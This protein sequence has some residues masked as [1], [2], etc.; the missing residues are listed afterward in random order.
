MVF[1]RVSQRHAVRWP[2][3]FEPHLLNS[4]T[5]ICKTFE[6]SDR[7]VKRWADEGAPIVVEGKDAKRRY[8]AELMDLHYWRVRRSATR[9]DSGD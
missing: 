6:V 2:L 7:T 5:E 9:E 3:V 4:L 8:S 1:P